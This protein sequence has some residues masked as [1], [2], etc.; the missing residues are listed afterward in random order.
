MNKKPVKLIAVLLALIMAIPAS[1]L[2][3]DGIDGPPDDTYWIELETGIS[4]GEAGD[5]A[6]EIIVPE[7]LSP[8]EDVCDS[9]ILPI[10][11]YVYSNGIL[12][13]VSDTRFAPGG[14]LTRAMAVAIIHRTDRLLAENKASEDFDAITTVDGDNA[15][16]IVEPA[17]PE[18][19]DPIETIEEMTPGLNSI[20]SLLRRTTAEEVPAETTAEAPETV[21]EETPK[22]VEVPLPFEIEAPETIAEDLAET[23]GT[24]E[25]IET[26]LPETI[27]GGEAEFP[28]TVEEIIDIPTV[29][30]FVDVPIDAYYAEA[31]EWAALNGIVHGVS[32]TEFAPDATLTIE[33]LCAMLFRYATA[34][35]LVKE[36]FRGS[37]RGYAY[38]SQ[39][40][41][42]AKVAAAWAMQLGF[43]R[44]NYASAYF[45][46]LSDATRIQTAYFIYLLCGE[47]PLDIDWDEELD[48]YVAIEEAEKEKEAEES[49]IPDEGEVV[50]DTV[51]IDET[52]MIEVL[53]T[54]EGENVFV[55]GDVEFEAS[56]IAYLADAD[57]FAANPGVNA[58]AVTEGG[59]ITF[60]S[61][62][63]EKTSGVLPILRVIGASTAQINSSVVSSSAAA[64]V[65][66]GADGAKITLT[67]TYIWTGAADNAAIS[68]HD[69]GISVYGGNIVTA[70]RNSP[71]ISLNSGTLKLA[72]LNLSNVT[73]NN[74]ACIEIGGNAG[75]DISACSISSTG[76]ALKVSGDGS[77]KNDAVI[78]NCAISSGED[79]AVFD[80][81]LYGDLSLSSNTIEGSDTLVAVRDTE[82]NPAFTLNMELR[83]QKASGDIWTTTHYADGSMIKFGLYEGSEWTGTFTGDRVVTNV[84]LSS[85]TLWNITGN[86]RINSLSV[87]SLSNLLSAGGKV[88]IRTNTFKVGN[89]QVYSNITY[90][91][92]K[93]IIG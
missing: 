54:V 60:D 28:E 21:S 83:G 86:C 78:K 68:G 12:R 11:L 36:S 23:P 46:P 20:G 65:I 39:V 87:A 72:S 53:P 51:V 63:V 42:W 50:D 32:E 18:P 71:A 93:V 9:P 74:S 76:S 73:A 38:A 57:F 19:S 91:S 81:T 88:E 55:G 90:G 33:Q 2:F 15:T 27:E 22:P 89:V 92:V 84:T 62:T 69:A 41:D 14:K 4:A 58:I 13:G 70:S 31:V 56:R 45:A 35:G 61:V 7:I 29:A 30:G 77:N 79:A 8:F 67:D 75:A 3:A 24:T 48:F 82:E 6:E 25:D 64:P 5:A 59:D 26:Q 17:E 52:D 44:K 43:L 1:A 47:E 80:V 37:I 34:S 10:I 49:L 85:G 16:I 40:H 66:S